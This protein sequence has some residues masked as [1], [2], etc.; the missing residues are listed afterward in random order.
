MRKPH[1]EN[2]HDCFLFLF[3]F[4]TENSL[5]IRCSTSRRIFLII[6][7]KKIYRGE[8][9]KFSLSHEFKF[10]VNLNIQP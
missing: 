8:A 4:S 10:A 5:T 3:Y 6:T 2:Q 1:K 9:S 7:F